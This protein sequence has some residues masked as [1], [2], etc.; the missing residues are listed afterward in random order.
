MF[1]RTKHQRDVT[2]LI[3]A[4]YF[5]A[6]PTAHLLVDLTVTPLR[7][8]AQWR[9]L[10]DIGVVMGVDGDGTVYR[11][12]DGDDGNDGSDD[13]SV[14][15]TGL[16]SSVSPA[17]IGTPV[18]VW[19]AVRSAADVDALVEEVVS[20]CRSGVPDMMMMPGATRERAHGGLYVMVD[21]LGSDWKVIPVENLIA[22][23]GSI[24]GAGVRLVM[25]C[26]G[27]EEAGLMREVME[28]GT[29]G[30]VVDLG[31]SGGGVGG[32]GARAWAGYV[33]EVYFGG[34]GGGVVY[35]VGV[36]TGVEAC[37]MG[38]R[39]CVDLAE[40]MVPGEGFLV[41]SFARGLF[42][43]HSE[44]WV[45]VVISCL[46]ARSLAHSFVVRVPVRRRVIST[47]GRSGS[48]RVPYIVTWSCAMIA[49]GISP[50]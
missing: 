21:A 5:S 13:G 35:G 41:G 3:E 17:A 20:L 22:A 44:W 6:S 40:N 2:D 25:A 23:F 15:T 39:V 31:D 37:G 36:V 48:T 12:D 38:D 28:V 11:L 19:R 18:G 8:V 1:V 50:S 9:V 7:T 27:M 26:G 49:R 24:G 33:R 34:G 42:L 46:P 45:F 29:D 4:G 30:V 32:V 10:G 47:R 16:A 43:V 14:D